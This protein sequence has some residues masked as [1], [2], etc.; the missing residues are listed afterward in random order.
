M[1]DR[2]R[3]LLA[4][5]AGALAVP[6][7]VQAQQ[8]ARIWRIGVLTQ[9]SRSHALWIAFEDALREL[10]YA[11]GRNIVL[12]YQINRPDDH[13]H[14]SASARDLV[15]AGVDV[16]VAGGANIQAPALKDATTTI[17]IVMLGPVQ[18]VETGLVESLARPGGNITGQTWDVSTEE[19]GKRLELFKQLVP[20]LS[21][22]ANLWDPSQP[23]TAAYWPDVRRSANALGMT[24]EAVPVTDT[25]ELE[26]VFARLERDRPGGLFI[27]GGPKYALRRE[28]ICEWA[29][30]AKIPTLGLSEQY[31]D[32]GCLLSYAP[33]LTQMYRGVA[34]YVDKILRGA[35]PAELPIGRPTKFTLAINVKTAHKLGLAVPAPLRLIADHVIE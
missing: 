28:E 5:L 20:K 33:N 26:G 25:S 21:R 9:T 22:L 15:A 29:L 18:V 19:A 10:G 1:M 11:E 17:P 14:V 24:A 7:R 13:L 6:R 32:A 3:F 34:T 2:R 16:I 27:W 30:K 8:A 23:G 31:V 12:R 4:S 35:K